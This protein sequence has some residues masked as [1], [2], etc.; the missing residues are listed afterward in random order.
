V[1][2]EE[3]WWSAHG[4]QRGHRKELERRRWFQ[5]SVW[6]ASARESEMEGEGDTE[7]LRPVRRV[8]EARMGTSYNGG[9]VAAGQSSGRGGAT[10]GAWEKARMEEL[11]R[12]PAWRRRVG[13]TRVENGTGRA[14]ATVSCGGDGK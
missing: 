1:D 4:G 7:R 11:E 3:L 5:S 12:R 14:A 10:W 8:K 13:A 2:R 6:N 9:K